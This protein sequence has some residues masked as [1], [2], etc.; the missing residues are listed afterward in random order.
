MI[1]RNQLSNEEHLS[2]VSLLKASKEQKKAGESVKTLSCLSCLLHMSKSSN[3]CFPF[4]PAKY[5]WTSS[6]AHGLKLCSQLSW[7][8][9]LSNPDIC[10]SS[11]SVL[12][13]LVPDANSTLGYRVAHFLAFSKSGKIVEICPQGLLFVSFRCVVK[14]LNLRSSCAEVW[15]SV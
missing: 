2:Q 11:A 5:G 13:H 14:V 8:F 3:A 4:D 9:T 1:S 12:F 10:N 15:I 6:D 7:E